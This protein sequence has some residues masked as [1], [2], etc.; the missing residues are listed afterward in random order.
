LIWEL[1]TAAAR[2]VDVTVVGETEIHEQALEIRAS[3]GTE[4]AS[5]TISIWSSSFKVAAMSTYP[6]HTGWRYVT[7]Q[8]LL[9]LLELLAVVLEGSCW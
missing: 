6:I 8:L 4:V 1:T 7:E 5:G 2:A 9:E 3:N